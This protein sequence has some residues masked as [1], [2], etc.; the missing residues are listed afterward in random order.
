MIVEGLVFAFLTMIVSCAA[1][2][3][4][5]R[6][7]RQGKPPQIR[8]LT[9]LDAINEGIGRA[10]EMGR[11]V[12]FS[13]GVGNLTVRGAPVMIASLSFLSHIAEQAAR[14]DCPLIATV[15][16]GDVYQASED[17]VRASYVRAGKADAFRPDA[18]RYLSVNQYVYAGGIVGIINREKVAVNIM[19]GH[20]ANEA[21]FIAEEAH[22]AGC[23][24]IAGTTNEYQIP[25]FVAACDYT[26]IGEELYAGAAY[27]S[28]DP[29]IMG[30]VVAQDIVRVSLY[31]IILLGGIVQWLSP[32]NNF[33][34]N[35]INF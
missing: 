33:I 12:H 24:Q 13:A 11:P 2:L 16:Q 19:I 22:S 35:F 5:I 14:F 34:R 32:Q 8:T 1:I 31:V 6:E 28:R 30:T 25:F 20:Y 18:V 10:T 27:V 9:A 23:L 26:M 4:G 17:I 3:L 29:V 15:A 21:L 7:A